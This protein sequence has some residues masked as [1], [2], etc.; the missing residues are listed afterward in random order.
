MVSFWEG[1]VAGWLDTG[2]LAK[3]EVGADAEVLGHVGEDFLEDDGVDDLLFGGE[4][5]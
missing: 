2:P 4:V 3:V 1:E 5:E